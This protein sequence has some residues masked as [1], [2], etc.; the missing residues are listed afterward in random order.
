M[1]NIT[2]GDGEFEEVTAPSKKKEYIDRY[3]YATA[4]N[5]FEL[6]NKPSERKVQVADYWDKWAKENDFRIYYNGGQRAGYFTIYGR[7]RINESTTLYIVISG[8]TT[9]KCFIVKC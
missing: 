7:K 6:Y 2:I 8:K 9:N 1:R 4:H 3:R 5:I